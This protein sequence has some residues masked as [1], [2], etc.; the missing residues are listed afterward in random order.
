MKNR[1]KNKKKQRIKA[2]ACLTALLLTSFTGCALDLSTN[3]DNS[4]S[5]SASVSGNENSEKVSV[6]NVE[7]LSFDTAKTIVTDAGLIYTV[8]EE[9][10]EETKGTVLMQYPPRD[11]KVDRGSSITL[12]I[13]KPILNDSSSLSSA[14]SSAPS[15]DMV[16]IGN[17]VRGWKLKD[18]EAFLKSQNIGVI[19]NYKQDPQES[20]AGTIIEQSVPEGTYLHKGDTIAF[21]VSTGAAESSA[22]P[23]QSKAPSA[24]PSL[25]AVALFSGVVASSTLPAE[26]GYTYEA[27]NI[28]R[29]DGTCWTEGV[30]GVGKG[31]YVMFTN[32][33]AVSVSGCGMK[34][35]YTIDAD[36]F[37]K[38]G[39]LSSVTF[40]GDDP[41]DSFTF[42]VDVYSMQE[43]KF[44]FP[45]TI[46]TKTL[47]IIISDAISGSS[48]DDT[49]ISLIIPYQ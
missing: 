24:A 28:L 18:A 26:K 37:T 35:G 9:E 32:S 3:E 15:G 43:Q 2:V 45:R 13:A 23:I 42:A 44:T 31:Q 5:D 25:S 40:Q 41:N 4:S 21:T 19:A 27:K 11:E 14:V 47:K 20:A 49:C 12:V 16:Y 34:N 22:A 30:K 33:S 8:V 46:K 10:S 36:R 29:D 39:R 17:Y 1:D 38:N 7:K 6:P 48:Y